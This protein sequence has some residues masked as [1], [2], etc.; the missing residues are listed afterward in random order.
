MIAGSN[1]TG[2]KAR[3]L[4]MASLMKLGCL[5]VAKDPA[6]PTAEEKVATQNAVQRYQAIFNSH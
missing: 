6:N 2:T 4:L 1:L 5:P 3:L